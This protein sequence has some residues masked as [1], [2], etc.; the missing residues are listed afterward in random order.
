MTRHHHHKLH[1]VLNFEI[2]L[3]KLD[4]TDEENIA[5]AQHRILTTPVSLNDVFIAR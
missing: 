1:Y 3:L 2:T 5:F 4:T